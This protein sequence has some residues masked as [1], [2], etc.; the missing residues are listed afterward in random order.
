MKNFYN[1]LIMYH[2][3]HKLSRNGWSK[4]RIASFLVINRRTVNKYLQMDE[5]DYIKYLDKQKTRKKKLQDYEAFVKIKLEKYPDTSSAQMHDW[6]KEHYEYFPN[7]SERTVFN[8]VQWI[9]QEHNIPKIKKYRD[10][11]IVEELPYGKQAQVDFGEY[12]MRDGKGNRVKIYFF[13]MVLSRSRYK[14]VYYSKTPFTTEIA[15]IAHLLAFEYF[16]GIPEEIVYDQDSVFIHDENSGDLILTGK[17]R[18]FCQHMGFNIHFCRKADPESKGKVE[19]VVKYIKQNFLYNR[20]FVDIETL[21]SEGIKWLSRTGNGKLHSFTKQKP[22]DAWLEEKPHLNPVKAYNIAP[23][24]NFYNIR[25]DNTIL[26]KGNYYTV[27][28]GTY[29]GKDTMANVKVVNNEILI[30]DVAM[31]LICKHELCHEKGKVISN[32]DHK[33]D[34]SQKI[35]NLLLETAMMF[36][37]YDLACEYLEKIRHKKSRYARDQFTL[38]KNAIEPEAPDNIKEALKYCVKNEIYNATDFIEVLKKI[39][40]KGEKSEQSFEKPE[41]IHSALTKNIAELIPNA[42]KLIDYEQIMKN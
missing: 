4:S 29:N 26:Y 7:V 5:E 34:K 22:Y 36:P 9:R 31:N 8:F 10:Y 27:P 33:R 39:T 23:K 38:I 19:N 37:D 25:K 17:F 11:F 3:I 21:N 2:E 28:L 32:T 41:K 42:S 35:D 24:S 13:A 15:I 16:G 18:D 12:N 1:K 30:H 6:L 14:F 20:P 40:E